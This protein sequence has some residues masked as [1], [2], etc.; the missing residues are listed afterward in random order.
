MRLRPVVLVLMLLALSGRRAAAQVPDSARG[1][2][3]AA[4][5][6]VVRDSIA[7]TPLAGAIV[8]L[9]AADSG[10]RSVRTA[11]SDSLGRFTLADVPDGRYLLGFFHPMLDSLGL[12]P[13][14]RAVHVAGGQPVRADLG[15]PSP[16]RLRAAICTALSA[17]DSGAVVVGVV[18]DARAGA[19]AAGATVTGEWLE[20]TFS[21]EGLSRRIP[22]LVTT[23]GEN[24][25]F[26]LCNVP[27]GGTMTLVASRGA[28]STDLIE[29]PV[30]ASGFLRRELY[31][32]SAR[33]VA[34]ATDTARAADTTRRADSLAPPSRRVHL[35]DGRLSGTVL[36]AEG[37]RPL[38]GAQ[39]GIVDGPRTRANERGEWTLVDAPGGTRMLEVRAVG[40]YPERR[41][42]D[43]VAGAAPVSVS[44]VT[45]QS[46]LDTVKVV[47]SR[48]RGTD[49]GR[50]E[51]R[52]RG[53]VGRYLTAEEIARRRPL[54]V[55]D[56]FR[57]MP[58]M[59]VERDSDGFDRQLL[60][61]G[62]FGL[63]T[64]A[65]YV[66]GANLPLS[67]DEIDVWVRPSDVAGIEIYRDGTVPPQFQTPFGGCGSIVIWRK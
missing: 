54:V 44:L 22:R 45:L 48:L 23:T 7:G 58:G 66:D 51:N 55:S 15:I 42:V 29:V 6:G 10:A 49:G 20:Y 5:S 41:S 50:F 40:Y 35:G 37:G 57:M 34:V 36:A 32:G 39:V 67:P 53:G 31:L 43:V 62:S 12:D 33:T 47:A 46:V 52:R 30:P 24:G 2:R 28:D 11:I 17:P 56:L 64:P 4:V 21:R 65:I 60:M 59:R 19:P 26:A 14:L 1:A 63:C 25:W 61:R 27:S 9:L 8:Q 38:S 3:G 18:R 13:P 16:A